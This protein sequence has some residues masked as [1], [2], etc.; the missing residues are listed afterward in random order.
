MPQTLF[1]LPLAAAALILAAPALAQTAAPAAGTKTT[2]GAELT[3]PSPTVPVPGSPDPAAAEQGGTDA[4]G[5]DGM[6]PNIPELSN[7]TTD[8]V[9]LTTDLVQRLIDSWPEMSAL[10]SDFTDQYG[11]D[12]DAPDPAAV[13][14]AWASHPEAKA[15]ID[16]V[17]AKHGFKDLD[18]WTKVANS[19]LIA[20]DWDD[21]LVDPKKIEEAVHDIDKTP[22]LSQAEK[23]A[24]IAQVKEQ[25]ASAEESRPLPGNRE[26]IAPFSDRIAK[27]IG[28]EAS[29]DQ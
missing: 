14:G 18:E 6:P 1:R 15:K 7:T 12:E 25:A 11:I 13:F 27:G 24:L 29:G 26:V 21:D 9:P 2:P 17:I 28:E 23:D 20:Y 10:A 19:I 3:A 5:A 16:A 4:G 22:G 8:Q